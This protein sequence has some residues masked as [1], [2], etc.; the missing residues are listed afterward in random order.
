[1][2][3][4]FTA[5]YGK[6]NLKVV[7]A[8]A[9]RVGV[10]LWEDDDV[11]WGGE[12]RNTFYAAVDGR[13]YLGEVPQGSVYPNATYKLIRNTNDWTFTD[14]FD[15]ALIQFNLYSK[16]QSAVEITDTQTKLCLLYD[17]CGLASTDLGA[18]W[19][20]VY[21][22]QDGSWLGK[23][24]APDSTSGGSVW[25]YAVQYKVMLTKGSTV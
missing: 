24:I 15:N 13:M 1:M 7:G 21:M 9:D 23:T 6:F 22:I 16:S 18:R 19:N 17:D 11:E 4:L 5:I 3:N 14:D 12:E 20:H 10:I 25:D 2:E 8:F